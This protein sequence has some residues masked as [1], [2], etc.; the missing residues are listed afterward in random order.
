MKVT[1]IIALII[2]IIGAINW[3]LIGV[4]DFDLV[5][6]IFGGSDSMASKVIYTLVGLAGIVNIRL[7]FELFDEKTN[8]IH[9]P[10]VDTIV[11]GIVVPE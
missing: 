11:P 7:L 6:S 9:P 2:T 1:Q 5:A 10:I 3:G 4:F 8:V